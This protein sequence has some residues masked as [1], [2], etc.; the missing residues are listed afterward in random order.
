MDV[1]GCQ[2][3]VLAYVIGVPQWIWMLLMQTSS[4]IACGN[5]AR[6]LCNLANHPARSS[7]VPTVSNSNPSLGMG[8]SDITTT[9]VGWYGGVMVVYWSVIFDVALCVYGG[10]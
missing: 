1:T 4:S 5:S 10:Q 8:R 6:L 7:S 3:S 2:V 9:P